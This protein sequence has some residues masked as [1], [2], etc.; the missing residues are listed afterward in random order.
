MAPLYRS[1][2]PR[3]IIASINHLQLGVLVGF[4]MKF[5]FNWPQF[6][7]MLTVLLTAVAAR[8]EEDN[9]PL[10]PPEVID[11][12]V[13]EGKENSQVQEHL[14]VICNRLGPRL[15]GSDGL[16]N[17]CEWAR[18]RFASMGLEARLEKW[19]EFPTGFNRGPSFG[20][21]V[22]PELM[23]LEFGTNAWTAGTKGR[24][25]RRAVMA[26]TTDE[27]WE[28]VGDSLKDAWVLVPA[29]SGGRFPR[30]GSREEWQQR[31]QERQKMMQRVR[32]AQPAGI[33]EPTRDNLIVTSGNYRLEW[34][35]VPT[36]PEI[37]LVVEQWDEL[38]K[39][40]K[41]GEEVVLEFDIR[42]F[43]EKGPIPLYNVIADIPGTEF[44]DEYVVIGGHLDSWDAATGATDNGAGCATT[45]E[46]ARILMEVGF[47]PRRTIRF[48]LW[49][50]EEQGLLGSRAYVQ[51]HP[52][53]VEK[54]SAVLVH[55]GGTNYASG[56]SVLQDQEEDITRIFEPVFKL[57]ERT[58]FDVEVVDRRGY[59]RPGGSD[60]TSFIRGGAPGFFWKQSGRAVY[61]NTHHTQFDTYDTVVPEYQRQTA[62]VVAVG[63]AGLASL[64]GLLS[65]EMLNADS[66]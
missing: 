15:T 56:I 35:D 66:E 57:D 47:K 5:R 60:H 59:G 40:I 23:T 20:R 52:E 62:V 64:D 61:R 33:I 17:A 27:E 16:Q 48:M 44:P 54:V 2:S 30:G 58:P 53:V 31:R 37:D 21:M 55:D 12:I 7:V 51:Q 13:A 65:R 38:A 18:D 11:K 45:I 22:E 39:R 8:A 42:N 10:V 9:Q 46:V 3:S 26:P 34:E 43:F 36:I 63:A 49:T 29:A 4:P 1:F 32:D 24:Q 6:L 19:G 41:D 14:D 28:S 25:A 50:G